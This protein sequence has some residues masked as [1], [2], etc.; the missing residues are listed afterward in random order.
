MSACHLVCPQRGGG[1]HVTATWTCS[2]MFIWDPPPPPDIFKLVQLGPHCTAPP[3]PDMLKL[4]HYE[5][6][7]VRKRVAGIRL[8]CFL[9]CIVNVCPLPTGRLVDSNNFDS[10]FMYV[11]SDTVVL[12][13]APLQLTRQICH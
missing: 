6:H 12:S 1:P 5:A 4:V 8:K 10:I 3:P 11:M 7:T 13:L 2:N 9:V